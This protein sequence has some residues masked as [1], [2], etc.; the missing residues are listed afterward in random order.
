MKQG[1]ERGKSAGAL[2]QKRRIMRIFTI[3]LF[4]LLILHLAACDFATPMLSLTQSGTSEPTADKQDGRQDPYNVVWYLG[5]TPQPDGSRVFARFNELLRDKLPNTTVDIKMIEWANYTSRMRILIAA[6]EKWDM[7]FT[8]SWANYFAPAV[9]RNA[10]SEIPRVMLETYGGDILKVLPEEVWGCVTVNDQIMAVPTWQVHCITRGFGVKK[11]L[12][13]KYK[14]QFDFGAVRCKADFEPFFELVKKN[15][16]GTTCFLSEVN[17]FGTVFDYNVGIAFDDLGQGM[18][19]RMDDPTFTVQSYFDQKESLDFFLLMRRWCLKGYIPEDASGISD[20]ASEQKSG[21]YAAFEVGNMKPDN[22]AEFTSIAY[23]IV[24]I[25]F[26]EPWKSTSTVRP[27]L[28]GYSRTTENLS[29]CLMLTNLLFEDAELYRILNHGIEGQNYTLLADGKLRVTGDGYNPGIDWELG[30]NALAYPREGQA[31]DIYDQTRQRNATAVCSPLFGWSMNFEPVK[32]EATQVEAAFLEIYP[33]LGTG[34]VD[35]DQ[36]I[37]LAKERLKKAGLD[38]VIA[39]AQRQVNDWL[40]KDQNL[41]FAM[42]R[43]SDYQAGHNGKKQ[44]GN[45]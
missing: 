45:S 33:I 17:G 7:C 35:L 5:G 30:N 26:T 25:Q 44:E 10:F 34:S 39:E 16:P 42:Q 32:N 6:K 15:E 40:K 20:W 41:A 29:R 14:P 38:I 1:I 4:I 27:G 31:A 28:F 21:K 8:A 36:F 19:V 22:A 43:I 13:E 18:I 12:Y 24:D 9:T 37:P 11:D 3:M 23:P 2:A